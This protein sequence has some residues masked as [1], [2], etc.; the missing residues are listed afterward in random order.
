MH[1]WVIIGRSQGATQQTRIVARDSVARAN[2]SHSGSGPEPTMRRRYYTVTS[3]FNFHVFHSTNTCAGA[4]PHGSH[5]RIFRAGS[6]GHQRCMLQRFPAIKPQHWATS[7][8]YS[9]YTLPRRCG[10]QTAIKE[11]ELRSRSTVVA[12]VRIVSDTVSS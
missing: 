1:P 9:K 2:E 4:N 6:R 5:A 8:G 12:S 10:A 11:N 3:M 7:R